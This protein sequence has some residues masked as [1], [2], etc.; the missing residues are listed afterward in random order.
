MDFCHARDIEKRNMLL[1]CTTHQ[2]LKQAIPL[3]NPCFQFLPQLHH[4]SPHLPSFWRYTFVFVYLGL[5]FFQSLHQ[6]LCVCIRHF[7]IPQ[8][9]LWYF[10][11]RS[12]SQSFIIFGNFGFEEFGLT[13]NFC[14][15]LGEGRG[16]FVG[17]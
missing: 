3:T 14:C 2:S 16:G 13:G 1:S 9:F 10:H 11:C 15:A 4:D 7:H 17:C 6:G 8:Q 5:C 12:I